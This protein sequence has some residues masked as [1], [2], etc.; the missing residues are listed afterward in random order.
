MN[1]GMVVT[2]LSNGVVLAIRQGAYDNANQTKRYFLE[3][4]IKEMTLYCCSIDSETLI[5][6][7]SVYNKL[8]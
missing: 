2:T 6:T 5:I 1:F 4:G 7:T 8:R 3:P